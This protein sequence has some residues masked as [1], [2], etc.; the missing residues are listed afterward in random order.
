MWDFFKQPSPGKEICGTC[1]NGGRI[2]GY[3]RY[4]KQ[5]SRP[6]IYCEHWNKEV[7]IM[8]VCLDYT[9]EKGRKLGEK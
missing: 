5:K 7:D 4:S 2:V 3:V 1:K 9:D 6:M 8:D